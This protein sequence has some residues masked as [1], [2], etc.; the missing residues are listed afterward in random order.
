MRHGDHITEPYREL[1][2]DE[3]PMLHP[4]A[5]ADDI[6][7]ERVL[8]LPP[9]LSDGVNFSIVRLQDLGGGIAD[10]LRTWAEDADP[11]EE[12]LIGWRELSLREI[13]EAPEL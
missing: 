11:D 13:E 9:E 1:A 12:I 4:E 2:G 3:R 7:R 5:R 10:A 6:P 8:V